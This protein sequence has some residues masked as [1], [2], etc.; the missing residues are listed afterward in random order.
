M[1][2]NPIKTVAMLFTLR[3]LDFLPLLD[4]NNTIINF[5]ESHKHLGI[6]LAY[7][8]QWHTHIETILSSVYKILGI[9]R[10]L[11]YRFSRQALNQM[12]VSYVRSIL[13]YSSIVWD[14][15]SEQDK[16]A[17]ERLQNEAA[18]IVTGLTKYTSFVNLYKDVA[19]IP[20]RK[21]DI[22][23]K[24][25]K[26]ISAPTTSFQTTYLILFH[27]LLERSQ[28]IP[29]T[30]DKILQICIRIQKYIENPAFHQLCL[31]G[32]ILTMI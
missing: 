28:T 20:F 29:C 22:F 19:G 23:K 15:C 6:T 2:F 21:E 32:I 24:C 31:I 13:E 3:P 11:K 9:M 5:V 30:V 26:C 4:F 16:T 7:N 1:D 27:H 18:R 8:G 25:A 14:G 10:K 12:Y 17:L